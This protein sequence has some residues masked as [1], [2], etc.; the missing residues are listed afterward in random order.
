MSA[1]LSTHGIWLYLDGLD[2]LVSNYQWIR[3]LGNE[4]RHDLPNRPDL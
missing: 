4:W 3:D 2:D 1:L